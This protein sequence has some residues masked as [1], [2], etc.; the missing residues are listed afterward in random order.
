L[1]TVKAE[2]DGRYHF[3]DVDKYLEWKEGVLQSHLLISATTCGVTTSRLMGGLEAQDV[4]SGT[5]LLTQILNTMAAS[6]IA[7][8]DLAALNTLSQSLASSASMSSAYSLLKH[9]PELA[10]NFQSL[11]QVAPDVL[12]Q[13]PP[14]ILK[15][16][17][18]SR[19][20]ELSSFDLKATVEHWYPTYKLAYLWKLGSATVGVTE[21]ERL[22]LSANSQGQKTVHLYVGEADEQGDLDLSRPYLQQTFSLEVDNTF[23][24]QSPPLTLKS[25]YYTNK[26]EDSLN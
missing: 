1:A 16:E 23:P 19:V 9:D 21:H 8:A 4:S 3:D 12:T 15:T 18:P 14:R 6:K 7:S 20:A 25:P 24:P 26:T 10:A 13:V 2:S 17:V 11:F 5:T 22:T